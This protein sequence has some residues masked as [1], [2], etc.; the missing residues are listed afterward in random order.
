MTETAACRDDLER[1]IG[2]MVAAYERGSGMDVLDI[3]LTGGLWMAE[4]MLNGVSSNRVIVTVEPSR[5]GA[6][7]DK[8]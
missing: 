4:D 3:R 6:R 5:K 8:A 1:A 7:Y 2:E